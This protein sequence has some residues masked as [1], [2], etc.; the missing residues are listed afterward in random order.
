MAL[1]DHIHVA[2]NADMR[3][4]LPY[5]WRDR[6]IGWIHRDRA[7]IVSRWPD[8][9]RKEDDRL[10]LAVEPDTYDG[11]SNALKEALHG[12]AE[13]G[14]IQGWR[15]ELYPLAPSFGAPAIAEFE[16]SA[17]PYLGIRAWGVHM[18][19]YVRKPDG[20]YIWVARRADDKPTYP[21]MLDNTVAGGLPMGLSPHE[22]M[23]KEC[24]E[25]A[26]IPENLARNIRP[27]GI[28]AYRHQQSEGLKP[29][30]MF[31]FDLELPAD[32]QPVNTDGE[33]GE[34]MLLPAE[35]VLELVRETREFKYNCNLCLIDFFIR[36][37]IVS[38]ENEPDYIALCLGLTGKE[39]TVG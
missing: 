28:I 33:V 39:S 30:Q 35:E 17:S 38:S 6:R 34:F 3:Q 15:G 16:R 22:N 27:V 13:V 18:T 10:I 1:I 20:L 26:G 29:D 5:F 7:D 8:A 23:V 4:F 24:D 12:L 32:F 37:G 19:G 31:C 2:N 9:F 21:G 14:E 25:E 11:R 36:H